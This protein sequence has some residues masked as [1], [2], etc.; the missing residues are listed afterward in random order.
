MKLIYPKKFKI[1]DGMNISHEDQKYSV[2]ITELLFAC[3]FTG[4]ILYNTTPS[5]HT[6]KEHFK[7]GKY[8]SNSPI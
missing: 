2:G 6:F 4:Y 1:P 5:Y 7:N 8:I 3:K